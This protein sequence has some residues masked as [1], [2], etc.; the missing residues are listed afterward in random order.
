MNNVLKERVQKHF[1][2]DTVEGELTPVS[3]NSSLLVGTY[4]NT[5]F[6]AFVLFPNTSNPVLFF[7]DS[8]GEEVNG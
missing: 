7:E 2:V 1:S 3:N 5:P 8:E 6:R 4:N